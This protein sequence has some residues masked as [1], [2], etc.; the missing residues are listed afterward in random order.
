MK[1]SNLDCGKQL[2]KFFNKKYG[3]ITY[4][5]TLAMEIAL[6]NL[7]LPKNGKVLISSLVCYSILNTILKLDLQ[8]FI[9]EPNNGLYFE[10]KDIEHFLDKEKI[11]CIIL[12][13]QYGIWNEIGNLKEKYPRIKII[14]DVAQAWNIKS[15]NSFVG[16]NSDI[17]I[18]SFGKTKPLSYGIGGGLF[19][20]DNNIFNDIDFSDNNSRLNSNI[21]LS[22]IYPLC[23][24]L[25]IDDLIKTGNKVV[26]EQ[27]N[28]ADLYTNFLKKQNTFKFIDNKN[29]VWHRYPIWV[30]DEKMYKKLIK[31]LE[32]TE[33]EYQLPHSISLQEIPLS[34]KYKVISNIFNKTKYFILLRTRNVNIKKQ[35][36]ILQNIL[37]SI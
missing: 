17:V 32:N 5:G 34:V 37:K 22:Y 3:I 29:N 2:A 30:E 33:L 27:R 15:D 7:N 24:K 6:K 9:V 16:E 19:F 1:E 25:E 20:D 31:Q 4:S 23:E 10:E 35:L 36:N 11:D 13:H 26:S 12:T 18:T 21:L 14:E 28:N 8:P